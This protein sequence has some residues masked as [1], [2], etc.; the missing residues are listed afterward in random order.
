MA[1]L[2]TGRERLDTKHPTIFWGDRASFDGIIGQPR[3]QGTVG[4]GF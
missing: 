2:G 4:N 1:V 3:R